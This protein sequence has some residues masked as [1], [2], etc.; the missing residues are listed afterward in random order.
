MEEEESKHV[1]SFLS[2]TPWYSKTA[3]G[4][5]LPRKSSS[6]ASLPSDLKKSS[7]VYHNTQKFREGACTNCGSLSHKSKDC[8][9][10]PRKIGAKYSGQIIP[11]DE[12]I[13]KK[14]QNYDEKHDR[15]SGYEPQAYSEVM[16]EYQKL[17]AAKK[18]QKIELLHQKFYDGKDV[19]LSDGEENEEYRFN[20]LVNN[21]DPRTKTVTFNNRSRDDPVCYIANIDPEVN[22]YDGKSRSFKDVPV[23]LGS[24]DQLYRDSWIKVDKD[25]AKLI[26][27]EKFVEKL[28]EKGNDVHSFATPSHAAILFNLHK[29]E[30][31]KKTSKSQKKLQEKYGAQQFSDS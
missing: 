12:Q 28:G 24:A 23:E 27:Q 20:V 14:V 17:E 10:R 26:E 29:E 6:K 21:V 18:K 31:S 25:M 5:S 16:D 19:D 15:W 11:Y 4:D 7:R 8:C 13:T 9:E 30:K 22:N 1:P 2:Q 3:S